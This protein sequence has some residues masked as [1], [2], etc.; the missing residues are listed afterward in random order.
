MLLLNYV[1]LCYRR[2]FIMND[3]TL[4]LAARKK[5][6][7]G[8]DV[9]ALFGLSPWKTPFALYQEKRGEIPD[10]PDNPSMAWGR[11]LEPAIRQHYANV[12]TRQVKLV[13]KIL[14]HPQYPFMLAN[15]DGIASD[16]R[17]LEIKT[18]RTA[19]GW[20]DA[21]T[22]EIPQQYLLQV[23]HYMAV[24]GFEVADV[25]VLIG[26]SD[27]RCYEIP[28]DKELQAMMIEA[29]A[30]FWQCI[31]DATPPEATSYADLIQKF[32]HRS[33][34]KAVSATDEVLSALRTIKAIKEHKELLDSK[35]Q[36]AKAVVFKLLRD[37]DTLID[38]KGAVIATWKI[39]KAIARLD[40]AA[41]KIAH[42][43]IYTQFVKTG[44]P[45]RRFLLK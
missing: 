18:S 3:R 4:W 42:P 20:G 17:V 27:F 40:S 36:L 28:A 41:L 7:G 21:D 31:L 38:S 13:D 8:S 25:A 26:G 11:A 5:G 37:A 1:Q 2:Y 10:Q 34:Q 43:E 32:G 29:E 30:K 16:S 33:T 12:T 14:V 6:I 23:Q 9:A 19:Q 45:T 15:V 24:T 44:E 39:A 35:E 22:D